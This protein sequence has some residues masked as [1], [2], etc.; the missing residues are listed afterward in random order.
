M[1]NPS[2]GHSLLHGSELHPHSLINR[3]YHNLGIH[4]HRHYH[5]IGRRQTHS[6]GGHE[7]DVELALAP[8]VEQSSPSDQPFDDVDASESSVDRSTPT[9]VGQNASPSSD[10]TSALYPRNAIGLPEPLLAGSL[11]GNPVAIPVPDLQAPVAGTAPALDPDSRDATPSPAGPPLTVAT[12]EA[13][14]TAAPETVP[15][16]ATSSTATEPSSSSQASELTSDYSSS[17]SIY[18]TVGDLHSGNNSMSSQARPGRFRHTQGGRLSQK[19]F[20]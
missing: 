2:S 9:K 18:S 20:S 3:H 11:L 8:S 7:N 19:P 15:H 6:S 1:A 17:P 10:S 4:S 14:T 12:T 16:S 13:S 5:R